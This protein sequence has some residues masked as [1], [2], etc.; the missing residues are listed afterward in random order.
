MAGELV[1][2][3]Q[4]IEL[5]ICSPVLREYDIQIAYLPL[6]LFIK[7]PLCGTDLC[8]PVP[9]TLAGIDQVI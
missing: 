2:P 7:L 4:V 6:S 5:S 3:T 8:L 9:M 1:I